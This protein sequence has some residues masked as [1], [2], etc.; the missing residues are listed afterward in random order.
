MKL[1]ANAMAVPA[2]SDGYS[3]YDCAIID[4]DEA[5]AKL[6]HQYLN[7]FALAE[8]SVAEVKSISFVSYNCRFYDSQDILEWNP[9]LLEIDGIAN[10]HIIEHGWAVLPDDFKEVAEKRLPS[11]DVEVTVRVTK[12]GFRWKGEILP[13]LD[14][15]ITMTVSKDILKKVL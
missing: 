9:S 14:T 6:L 4:M 15:L 3:F 11:K 8:K 13:S 2:S 5:N 10:S 7:W 12:D 1:F